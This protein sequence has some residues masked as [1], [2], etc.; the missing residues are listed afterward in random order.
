[1]SSSSSMSVMAT[2]DDHPVDLEKGVAASATKE[3]D[4][5]R[6]TS[7]RLAL[8]L[9]VLMDVVAVL[10]V[11]FCIGLFA[12]MFSVS[13]KW[14]HPLPVIA[15]LLPVLVLTLYIKPK[16]NYAMAKLALLAN[17]D[18]SDLATKLVAQ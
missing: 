12:W 5:P 4:N 10:D 2:S 18:D 6:I 3:T 1:M 14:W 13:N 8:C 17:D 16:T 11:L 15:V 7:P 9:M